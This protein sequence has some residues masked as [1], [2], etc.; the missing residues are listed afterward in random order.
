[1]LPTAVV[2]LAQITRVPPVFVP[3]AAKV[4]NLPLSA[5]SNM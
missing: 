3:V 2:L 5:L 4:I 1:M